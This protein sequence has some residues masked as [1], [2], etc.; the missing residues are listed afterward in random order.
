MRVQPYP[1]PLGGTQHS[2]LLQRDL[3]RFQNRASLGY[4]GATEAADACF[5]CSGTRDMHPPVRGSALARPPARGTGGEE[6]SAQRAL[7][8]AS[9]A[10]RSLIAG[11]ELILCV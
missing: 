2:L 9:I 11:A 3:R 6:P 10:V 1:L 5:P 8:G 4:R 7:R